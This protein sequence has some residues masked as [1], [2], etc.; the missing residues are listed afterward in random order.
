ME[1]Y[2]HTYLFHNETKDDGVTPYLSAED[3]TG[4]RYKSYFFKNHG[5]DIVYYYYFYD[6]YRLDSLILFLPGVGPGHKAYL[7]E[8]E[9]FC[10]R[11]Y[12][13]LTLD[14]SGCGQS[15]NDGFYSLFSPASDTIALINH[16]DIREE[17]V[18]V[19]HSLGGFTGLTVL[20]RVE[21]IKKAV[22]IS[23]FLSYKWNAD[24]LGRLKEISEY[25]QTVSPELI[26]TDIVAFLQN[27][28]D[29]IL[30]IHSKDDKIVPYSD[31][32]QFVEK[33]AKNPRFSFCIVDG[34]NHNPNYTDDALAYMNEVFSEYARLLCEGAFDSFEKK[35]EYMKDK[36]PLKM[37][38]Q[39]QAI[40]D[41]IIKLIEK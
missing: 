10:K 8:I 39:D 27:T 34:R 41:E 2:L 40:I 31:T 4:L 29:E 28:S 17:I 7:R 26:S 13:V 5:K 33:N 21:R 19:G 32:T 25:E 24:R 36:S 12:R 22:I 23:G 35:K 16:A 6:S 15:G 20:S 37:T 3:F 30:F 18:I 14:Y 9:T 38:T 11:G 1:D